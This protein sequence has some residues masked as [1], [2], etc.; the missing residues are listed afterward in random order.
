MPSN[1][2][3][4]KLDQDEISVIS[5]LVGR[6]EVGEISSAKDL[7]V[8][9]S[10]KILSGAT[11]FIKWIVKGENRKKLSFSEGETEIEL[12]K[13]KK[14][15]KIIG[16]AEARDAEISGSTH[17][18]ISYRSYYKNALE[19]YDTILDNFEAEKD[20]DFEERTIGERALAEKIDLAFGTGQKRTALEL[21][22]DF[23]QEYPD[24][25]IKPDD[26]DS[27]SKLSSLELSTNSV[28][29][30]GQ[31]FSIYLERVREPDFNEYGA[32]IIA[33]TPEGETEAISL[34]K[35]GVHAF[36]DE[37]KE[38]IQLLELEEDRALIKAN[39]P[40][41]GVIESVRGVSIGKN[42][43]LKE[44]FREGV[45]E[46]VFT[47][48]K[49]NL[50]RVAVVS[51]KPNINYARTEADFNFKIGIE[52]RG[53][54]LSPEK[55]RE[56]IDSLNETLEKW[57]GYS[58]NLG[59]V[60][61]GLKTAC[62]GTGAILTV[63]NFF[64][65]LGGKGIARQ[66]IMRNEG[67]WVDICQDMIPEKYDSLD[68][69]FLNNSGQINIAVD[70]YADAI[71]D[72]NEEI[73]DLEKGITKGNFLSESVVDTDKLMERYLDEDYKSELKSSLEGEISEVNF[74]G[75]LVGVSEII[76][77]MNSENVL[78]SQARDLQLN[79]RLLNSENEIVRGLARSQL[80]KDLGN[81]WANS[82]EEKERIDFATKHNAGKASS[83][84]STE[85][86][87]KI[88][89]TEVKTFGEV[90][91]QYSGNVNIDDGTYVYFLKDKA[92]GVKEYL[93][94][95]DNDHAITQTYLIT[96]AGS[97]IL[98]GEV[99]GEDSEDANPLKLELTK[100]DRTT[101]E[102]KFVDEEIRYYET[103]PYQGLPAVVPFD[104]ENGWYAAIKSTL[105]IGGAIR[106]YDDSGRVSSFY[107]CNV[108]RDGREEFYSGI[109]DDICEMIN[110]GTGQPYNQFPGLE[111]GDASRLVNRAI[112]AIEEA[113][114]RY[115]DGVSQV[116]IYGQTIKVGSPATNIPDIQ[117]QDFMSPVDCNI[118][119]NVCDP[120]VCPSSRCDFDGTYP[121]KDVI[122]S[123]IIGSIALCLP[124][125]PEVKVPICLSGVHAGIEGYLSVMDSYQQCL[126]TSLDTGETVGICDEIRSIHLCEFFWRQS[127][128]LAKVAVPRILGS[129]MGQNVRG[130]GE[131]LGVVDAW[132]TAEESVDYY[133]QYYAANSYKA[134]KARYA[135]GVGG[136][137]CKNYVSW[138]SPQGGNL[139]DALTNPD[140]PPQYH[141]WFDEIP[142][143]TATNPPISQYKV[144]YHI[145]A[146]KD[147]RAYYQVY[148]RDPSGGSFY[149]DTAFRRMVATGFIGAGEYATETRDLTAP[150]GYKEMCIVVNGQEECGFKV[151]STSFAVNY[152]RDQYAAQQASRTDITSETECISGTPS[153]YSLLNPNLQAG[154]E[155]VINPAIY[156]QGIIRICATDNP[157]KGTDG[158]ADDPEKARWR[159]VGYC[160]DVD[161]K[162]WLDA[163][164]VENAVRSTSIEEEILDEVTDPYIEQL[165]KER[166]ILDFKAFLKEIEDKEGV[167]K[168]DLITENYERAF[169]NS[170]KAYLFFLRGGAY[171]ELALQAYQAFIDKQA[172]EPSEEL[173]WTEGE[174]ERS[175]TDCGE[176]WFNRCGKEECGFI[177]EEIGVDCIFVEPNKCLEPGGAET[178]G[179]T[180]GEPESETPETCDSLES[181]RKLLGRKIM[182]LA[183]QQK[184]EHEISD[185][186]VKQDT[187]S[188]SFECLVLQVAYQESTIQHCADHQQD[189]NPLYCDGDP[190]EIVI[191]DY[192]NYTDKEIP[193]IYEFL[194]ITITDREEVPGS[195]GIMQIHLPTHGDTLIQRNIDISDFREN[196]NYGIE[197][198]RTRHAR[199][200]KEYACKSTSYSGWQRALR[201]YNGWNT[202]CSK[203]DVDYVDRIIGR[204]DEIAALFPK[205]C[206]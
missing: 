192:V 9:V 147:S 144:F 69:C 20:L 4:N 49:I 22:L 199:S 79:S 91:N 33:T 200:L 72:L 170:E 65:N 15:V 145:Y 195:A 179:W 150:S 120:V 187:G 169:Y 11:S 32:T 56:R 46:Y 61:K 119:F 135:E 80:E 149:Q 102:N 158:L 109:G 151:A 188:E 152:V 47:L 161:L 108:G 42:V 132:Q 155:D 18:E 191:G 2:N 6:S 197:L 124:N 113:S 21:C 8:E 86:L 77:A 34:T 205:E 89:I 87:K 110:L 36:D 106:A 175:C 30:N 112:S 198:L 182:N 130:G 174:P 134:F 31:T 28:S 93:L 43:A 96:G 129:V 100:Y 85:E 14:N 114:K 58:D 45:G 44:G 24:S 27:L 189:G 178:I 84:I 62:L 25:L 115:R 78:L 40:L 50:E 156:N 126:Q 81:I 128:P 140:S 70:A 66:K 39:V 131:Y 23:S 183:L 111:E 71:G 136:E 122:Q 76:D 160:G 125:F 163:E 37:G 48:E 19:D 117:C 82:R 26:C 193:P 29:I 107:L 196:V 97:L 181:C 138:T 83:V 186:E 54:Q 121:V 146:G 1:I 75:G 38:F 90:K 17:D 204:K 68:A 153:L 171:K 10:G 190:N 173:T 103:E 98:A 184:L 141:G 202:D 60:V 143:T 165:K 180:E 172:K 104:L 12:G 35:N 194:G 94:V 168:I 57:R 53:I 123:G 105:P 167:E 3:K 41:T 95:L 177:G 13:E 59:S 206:G 99:I 101:Y 164:S 51:I 63:K 127:L 166:G 137:V 55:T 74:E 185:A 88:A 154:V 92:K 201:E 176:G 148:L 52:K 118:L 157:G 5:R 7:L 116:N 162:C 16:F 203:G 133:T 73:D 64:A 159:E 142:F 139:L 67:G